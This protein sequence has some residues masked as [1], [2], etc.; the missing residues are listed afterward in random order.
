MNWHQHLPLLE[1]GYRIPRPGA[2]GVEE[3]QAF[4]PMAGVPTAAAQTPLKICPRGSTEHV[5][6]ALNAGVVEL[7]AGR[8]PPGYHP[9]PP[10]PQ[11]ATFSPVV[12][13]DSSG[14]PHMCPGDT[15]Y[16]QGLWKARTEQLLF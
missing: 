4:G 16:L 10:K 3:P 11:R 13:R 8:R 1:S 2:E 6:M 9:S 7:G 5:E 12:S 14:D 15:P